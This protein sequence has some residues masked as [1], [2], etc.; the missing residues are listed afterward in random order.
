[1][2]HSRL[3]VVDIETVPERELMAPDHPA[4]KPP[5]PVHCRIVAV[6]FLS[7]TIIREGRFERFIVD[8]CRS[9]GGLDSG[10]PEL[11]KGFWRKLERDK[12]RVVTWNGR[13]FDI[14]VL[15][16]RAMVHGVPVGYWHQAGDKWNGYR[17]RYAPDWHCDL[18]DALADH[19]A[20]VKLGLNEAAAAVG[21]PG[22]IGAHGGEVEALAAAGKLDV[23]RAYC[24][25]DVLNLAG[26]YF[27][28]AYLTGRTD[29]QRYNE[30]IASLIALLED[31]RSTRP[32]FG[33]FLD[34]WRSST[35][36]APMFVEV[37]ALPSTDTTTAIAVMTA[38]EH[39]RDEDV[40]ST[41][42]SS[43]PVRTD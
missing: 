15:L 34:K 12:P 19:G 23:V 13:G 5:K 40:A 28:W 37:P 10:E 1:V 31:Q 25:C 22:K 7:A 26:L 32:H 20:A 38:D 35:R 11:V 36:P 6:S 21:L 27:R 4:D 17:A 43:L 33:E 29:A 39:L 41:L 30:A 8:E 2:T 24:E 18:M 42:G 3:L 14:P 16:L 9:G